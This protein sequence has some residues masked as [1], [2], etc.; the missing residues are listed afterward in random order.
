MKEH[1]Q[2][3]GVRR[4]AGD[5]LV[6]L[7]GEP[8][9]AIQKLVEPYA[10]C[11]IQGCEVN[12]AEKRI[13]SGMV[14]LWEVDENNQKKGVKIARFAGCVTEKFPVYLSLKRTPEERVYVD[15]KNKPIAHNYMAQETTVENDVKDKFPLKITEDGGERLVD[16]IGITQKL[17]RDG[18]NASNVKVVSFVTDTSENLSNIE[19]GSSLKELFGKIRRWF[20][21]LGKLAFKNAVGKSD[22]DDAL[23]TTFNN[24][25][26]K[27]GDKVLSECDFSQVYKDKLD[28]IA[29]NAEVNVQADW[30]E[31]DTTSDAFIKNKPTALRANGGTADDISG[32]LEIKHGG[33]GA[34][35][36]PDAVNNLLKNASLGSTTPTDDAYIIAS[37]NGTSN[38][39]FTKKP[40]SKLWLWIKAKLSA[41]ATSGSYNDLTDKPTIPTVDTALSTTSTNP[42]QNKIVKEALDG[43]AA[44]THTHSYLP[45]AGGTI[46]GN[47]RLKGSGNYGNKL[48]FGDSEYVYLH[49]PT[50]DSLEIYAEKGINLKTS[51]GI[52]TVKVNGTAIKDALPTATQSAA[53][54]MSKDDK[55][56]L[57]FLT[58]TLQVIYACSFGVKNGS[59]SKSKE[60]TISGVSVSLTY[61]S[62]S[63]GKYVQVKT[64]QSKYSHIIPMI[65]G[66]SSGPA[67]IDGNNG[68][69]TF[70]I[71][72]RHGTND[73]MDIGSGELILIGI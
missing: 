62:N 23:T 17:D 25:V 38:T 73:V 15:G 12:A 32:V 67:F 14:A 8:L 52:S 10:P 46:T 33:T 57:D 42:V 47:L 9:E 68:C 36:A 6:E 1:V 45:L 24:K 40:L 13:G 29:K 31:T 69:G 22:F 65:T 50:D 20:N 16:T 63:E 34:T 21:N 2:E 19:A 58:T 53:G 56:N 48:N 35:T 72:L 71:R 41:V 11:I 59:V 70:R 43:K 44:S 7:Q 27:D 5:D 66:E 39:S 55:S 3:Y 54:L 26:D 60:K 4:W 37:G 30:S 49:E 28:G 64:T 61:I 18:G 51:A